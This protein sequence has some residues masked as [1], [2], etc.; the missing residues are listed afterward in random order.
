[1]H[2]IRILVVEDDMEIHR[3]VATYLQRE[4]YQVESAYNGCGITQK[5]ICG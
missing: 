3:L 2:P 4:G 5:L 1:M